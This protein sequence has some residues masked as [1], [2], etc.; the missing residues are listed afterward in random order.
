MDK[1]TI[2]KVSGCILTAAAAIVMLVLLGRQVGV[3]NKTEEINPPLFDS[4]S[5]VEP[6]AAEPDLSDLQ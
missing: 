6:G 5:Y 4:P 3:S 1:K 2:F